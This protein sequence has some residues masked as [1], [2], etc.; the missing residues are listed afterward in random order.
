M[1]AALKRRDVSMP[2]IDTR[3]GALDWAGIAQA[4]DRHGCAT[5]GPLL[6]P[7]ECA[8]LVASY[9]ADARFRSR[10]VMAS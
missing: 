5:T 2:G 8:A 3:V 10:V 1:T 6:T 7:A 4:L 9:D